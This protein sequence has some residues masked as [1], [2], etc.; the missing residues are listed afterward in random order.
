MFIAFNG[1][2]KKWN[3]IKFYPVESKLLVRW[4]GRKGSLHAVR[5][6]WALRTG[7]YWAGLELTCKAVS[8]HFH[9]ATCWRAFAGV[10][11][12]LFVIQAT[13][14]TAIVRRAKMEIIRSQRRSSKVDDVV[15]TLPLYRSAPPLQVRLEDF[16]LFA[17]DRLRGISLLD[18]RLVTEKIQ[19]LKRSSIFYLLSFSLFK[20]EKSE[21]N[22]FLLFIPYTTGALGFPCYFNFQ[23]L[24]ENWEF[25]F[26]LSGF[27]FAFGCQEN[28][29]KEMNSEF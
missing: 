12:K 20:T 22:P 24:H 6:G 15:S 23:V 1:R 13:S 14:C 16:E 17:I 19:E 4:R 3:K 25:H 21:A 29:G 18:I 11:M 28:L 27:R 9:S 2:W 7:D 5:M 10:K 26:L 8:R